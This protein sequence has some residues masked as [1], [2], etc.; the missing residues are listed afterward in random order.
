MGG[1]AALQAARRDRRFDAVIDVDGYPHGP[2]STSRRSR[3]P[4][5]SPPEPTR[6]TSPASPR[7]SSS[8]PQRVTGS[9]SPAPHTSP[10]WTAPCTCR[11]RPP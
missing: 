7:P 1:A 5:P 10:S 4:R 8:T 9:P 3:S 11:P 2:A 6:T